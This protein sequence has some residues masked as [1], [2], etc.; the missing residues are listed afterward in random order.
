MDPPLKIFINYISET[1]G[2]HFIT[3]LID[4]YC[5][6]FYQIQLCTYRGRIQTHTTVTIMADIKTRRSCQFQMEFKTSRKS[7]V[8]NPNRFMDEFPHKY[9]YLSFTTQHG[10][11]IKVLARF[12][13]R[14][15]T[16]LSTSFAMDKNVGVKV[17]LSFTRTNYV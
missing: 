10:N 9:L 1:K 7:L 12:G 15:R 2:R 5:K 4:F 6:K 17:H 11:L 14:D 8:I 3:Q 13:S 16:G